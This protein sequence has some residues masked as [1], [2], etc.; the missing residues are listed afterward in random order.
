MD[1]R[2][3]ASRARVLELYRSSDVR[4]S[5]LPV[6]GSGFA[7]FLEAPPPGVNVGYF[8]LIVGEPEVVVYG[9]LSTAVAT[10]SWIYPARRVTNLRM[11][12]ALAHT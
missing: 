11:V 2:Y 10:L 1:A 4:F 7:V 12:D 8:A 6:H 9:F 5:R 3:H